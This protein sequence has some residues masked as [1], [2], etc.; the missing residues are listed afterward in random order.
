MNNNVIDEI[1]A[2][3]KFTL[4]W[5]NDGDSEH[6]FAEIGDTDYAFSIGPDRDRVSDELPNHYPFIRLSV[7]LTD[8]ES[9]FG[10]GPTLFPNHPHR[11]DGQT[12]EEMKEANLLFAKQMAEWL[13]KKSRWKKLITPDWIRELNGTCFGEE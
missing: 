1:C 8:Y 5:Y 12:Y 4:E 6:L 10:D 9:D 11:I 3:S 13:L 7:C 2:I